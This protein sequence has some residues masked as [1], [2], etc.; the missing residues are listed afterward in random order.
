MSN[1]ER[2][3]P[4]KDAANK[5]YTLAQEVHEELPYNVTAPTVYSLLGNLKLSS[6]HYLRDMLNDM[7][8][9]L[10]R[11]LIDFDNYADDKSNPADAV[12]KAN[13]HI[14]NAAYLAG[15]LAIQ[16]EAAQT[17]VNKIGYKEPGDPGYR[18]PE[19]RK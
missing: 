7:A 10:S 14:K 5:L 8:D 16:L 17:A 9:G 11:S 12:K 18:K 2:E 19:D 1:V 6:G 3:Q 4:V 15:Q 13:E